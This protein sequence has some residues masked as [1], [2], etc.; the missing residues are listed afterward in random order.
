VPHP[1][2]LQPGQ[3]VREQLRLLLAAGRQRPIEHAVFGIHVLTVSSKNQGVWH[4][5]ESTA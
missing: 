1:V 3:P 2:N 4:C 5:Y